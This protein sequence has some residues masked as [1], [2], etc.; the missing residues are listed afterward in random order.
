[1]VGAQAALATAEVV[2]SRLVMMV[3]ASRRACGRAILFSG[4]GRALVGP[5]RV[6]ATASRR[7]AR[8]HGNP[9]CDSKLRFGHPPAGTYLLGGSLP[10]GF[11]PKARRARRFGA[12]GALL[13]TPDT[14]DAR[15]AAE[16]GRRHLYLHGG[17]LDRIGRLRPTLGGLRMADDDLLALVRAMNDAN[18]AGDPL[19]EIALVQV[20]D[21]EQM[22][23]EEKPGRRGWLPLEA[24]RGSA[25]MSRMS[26][27][28]P[29]AAF[30]SL[31]LGLARRPCDGDAAR[32]PAR[33]DF[34]ALAMLVASGAAAVACGGSTED[35]PSPSGPVACDPADPWCPSSERLQPGY[36]WGKGDSVTGDI[37]VATDDAGSDSGSDDNGGVG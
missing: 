16:N 1:M 2:M 37:I 21:T 32:D 12:V 7:A 6:L 23:E 10:P 27:S 5:F 17:P 9:T 34:L 36:R 14:G 29:S 25:H 30:A 15:E 31:A 13:L 22:R 11:A 33:R 8:K 26:F 24:A 18:A 4:A 3:P 19:G 28:L 35:T 20:P